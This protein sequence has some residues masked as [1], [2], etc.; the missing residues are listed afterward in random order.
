MKN[1][2]TLFASLFVTTALIAQ[3]ILNSEDLHTGYSFN[4]YLLSNVNTADLIPS[5]ANITWDLS[6]TTATLI[7]TV[8][9]LEMSETPY[10][11]EY[12]EANF[13]MKFITTGFPTN[14]S[15][16]NHSTTKFE[17][18]ANNVGTDNPVSFLNYRTVLT[19]PFTFNLS[20][21]DT[22]QKENQEEKTITITYDSYGTFIA[23][24]TTFNNTVR[25]FTDDDTNIALTW[26][27]SSPSVPIFRANSEGFILWQIT[28]TPTGIKEVY[29]NQL[30]D[31]YPNPAT[32]ELHILNKELLSKIEIYNSAGQFQFSTNQSVIDISVL[33]PG[34]YI[35]KAWSVK[36]STSQQFVKQ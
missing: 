15:L 25:L 12:P 4:Q 10:Q 31:M 11:A 19:F 18:V 2:Y 33:K 30:F 22:Y 3:P 21:T 8:D 28:S 24:D 5:G 34:A 13:A 6:N 20:I 14:Y 16:F 27:N 29:S 26:W 36:G 35:L 7:G 32:N 17:E 23:N 9:F 1:I